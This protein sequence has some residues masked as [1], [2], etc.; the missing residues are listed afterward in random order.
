MSRQ[1]LKP[2]TIVMINGNIHVVE[3]DYEDLIYVIGVKEP[4]QPNQV[5]KA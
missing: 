4:F 5:K 3:Y 2:G 1:L